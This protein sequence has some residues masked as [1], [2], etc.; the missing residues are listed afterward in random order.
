[1]PDC[2]DVV[3]VLYTGPFDTRPIFEC[4]AQL[5]LRGSK[6]APGY[7]KPEGIV[8]FHTAS[9]T[10]YKYTLGNDACANLNSYRTHA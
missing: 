9:G 3:P 6:A 4:A 1:M 7:M 5:G 10:G 8:V 2:C